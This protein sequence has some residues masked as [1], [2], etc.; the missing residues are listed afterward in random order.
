MNKIKYSNI[1]RMIA[2]LIQQV[3]VITT[4]ALAFYLSNIILSIDDIKEAMS[5]KSYLESQYFKDQLINKIYSANQF[6]DYQKDFEVAGEYNG[7][8]EVTISQFLNDNSEMSQFSETQIYSLQDLVDWSQGQIEM[9]S[10]YEALTD[11]LYGTNNIEATSKPATVMDADADEIDSDESLTAD[12]KTFSD[13]MKSLGIAVT[14]DMLQI[15]VPKENYLTTKTSLID[16]CLENDDFS[17][18]E[19]ISMEM[20]EA[21]N[22]IAE[23]YTFYN[24]YAAYFKSVDSSNFKIYIQDYKGDILFNN[25][26]GDNTNYE[27]YFNNNISCGI[28]YNATTNEFSFTNFIIDD[29]YSNVDLFKIP[30]QVNYIYAVGI[31]S[32]YLH[33]D[34]FSVANYNYD[35]NRDSIIVLVVSM[36]II[37]ICFIYLVAVSGRSDKDE[38]IHLNGFDKIKTEIGAGIGIVIGAGI[39]GFLPINSLNN[40]LSTQVLVIGVMG[41][42]SMLFTLEFLS[43][44][45]RIK[46]GQLWKNSILY[47]IIKWSRIFFRYRKVTTKIVILYSAF[48]IITLGLLDIVF[49]DGSFFMLLVWFVFVGVVGIILLRE[50]VA[51]QRIMNGIEKITSGDLDNKIDV[52]DLKGSNQLLAQAINNIGEGLHNAVDASMRNERLKTDL[53]TNVSHDIKTPLTSIINYVDLIKRENIEDEKIKGYVDI[54]DKKSQRLKNLT[55]DLVEASKISSGNIKLEMTKINFVELIN[56]TEGEFSEKFGAKGLQVIKTIPEDSVSINADG[57]R[58]WRVVENLYNNIAKYA[59]ENSRVY[60]DLKADKDQVVFSVK[61]ISEHPLNINADELTERFIRGDVS[62]STE[63]SG[64]GL[65]IAK[66]LTNL[67]K[68]TFEIY[69]DGDLFRVTITFP[70]VV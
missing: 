70:R 63:G 38:E 9:I 64:L 29:V 13:N 66:N 53:I 26:V 42:E 21:L 58:I 23:E 32:R 27:E 44:T 57:R 62:R 16:Y 43:L 24:Q 2:F 40:R 54:L 22:N 3:L 17:E 47:M 11:Y 56:Q 30:D 45:K 59:M 33:S 51:R 6:M 25:C 10:L 37:L 35:H 20:Q 50:A 60:I 52:T 41:L 28:I 67:Q 65:S 48:L 34:E 39:L 15:E 46:A 68:G 61:N 36:L 5:G 1:T 14:S 12:Y 18:I 55:E 7:N 49:S 31:D 4:V 69:L 8:K 19:K